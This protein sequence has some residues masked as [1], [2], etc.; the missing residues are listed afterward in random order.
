MQGPGDP[1]QAAGNLDRERKRLVHLKTK[2]L[3]VP[4]LLL[5]P[6]LFA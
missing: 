6:R 5:G 3:P 2:I 4:F 1:S